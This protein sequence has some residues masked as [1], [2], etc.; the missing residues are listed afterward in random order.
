ME[1]HSTTKSKPFMCGADAHA[2]NKAGLTRV[3]AQLSRFSKGERHQNLSSRTERDLSLRER[4]RT[5]FAVRRCDNEP[6]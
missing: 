4:I 1:S 3:T 5:L 6:G 2:G